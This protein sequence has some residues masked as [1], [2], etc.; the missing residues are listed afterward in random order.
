MFTLAAG[1]WGLLPDGFNPCWHVKRYPE[2]KRERFLAPEEYERLWATLAEPQAEQPA[3]LPALNAIRLLAL[4]GCRLS[5]IQEAALGARAGR[6]TGAA[7]RQ[8]RRAPG[9]PRTSGGERPSLH[10]AVA[11]QPLRDH[12]RATRRPSD[13]PAAARGG[14]SGPALVCRMFA[15]TTFGIRSPRT[16]LAQ[17]RKPGD[18]RQAVRPQASADNRAV[19]ARSQTITAHGRRSRQ[20]S[21]FSI[22][23]GSV[24]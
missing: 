9:L 18:D 3:M 7:R 10:R 23:G 19:R 17:R 5:E 15:S 12:R 21:D 24:A 20:H 2:R 8:E 4:T 13:R 22:I 14:G 6:N 1:D 16:A 11:R